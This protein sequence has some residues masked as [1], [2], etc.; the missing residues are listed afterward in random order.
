MNT[1]F[2]FA[3][4][5]QLFMWTRSNFVLYT[6]YLYYRTVKPTHQ[7]NKRPTICHTVPFFGH[8]SHFL[9]INQNQASISSPLFL[10]HISSPLKSLTKFYY[11]F[12]EEFLLSLSLIIILYFCNFH[13]YKN[14]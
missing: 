8:K 5:V 9:L 13:M 7:I 6:L 3:H 12:L 2:N 1:N 11:L 4:I 10:Q 14:I